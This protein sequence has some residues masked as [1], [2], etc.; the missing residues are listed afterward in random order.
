MNTN[1]EEEISCRICRDETGPLVN[2]CMCAGSIAYVHNPCLEKWVQTRNS[3]MCEVCKVEYC[4]ASSE[5]R[6]INEWRAPT[7]LSSSIDD[8]IDF[9]CTILW[10]VFMIRTVYVTITSG[11]GAVPLMV[12]QVLGNGTVYLL[13]WTS[14]WLNFLYYG[15]ISIL[16]AERWLTLNTRFVFTNRLN[17]LNHSINASLSP[18][19]KTARAH[20]M[21]KSLSNLV[22]IQ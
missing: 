22:K 21:T 18:R 8:T 5:L 4:R 20:S 13:W 12:G 19:L 7:P 3:T 6:P 11:L 1:T 15:I 10:V 16:L 9:Y 17:E 14:F 2:P